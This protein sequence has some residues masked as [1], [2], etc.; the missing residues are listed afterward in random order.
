MA[1][2]VLDSDFGIQIQAL[3]RRVQETLSYERGSVLF[4]SLE[5][6]AQQSDIVT[7][8]A[9][10]IC[11]RAAAGTLLIDA[12]FQSKRITQQME[13]QQGHGLSECLASSSMWY[14]SV[15]ATSCEKLRFL[16]SGELDWEALPELPDAVQSLIKAWKSSFG[17][18]VVDGGPIDQPLTP[19]LAQLA[20][21]TY[22]TVRLGADEREELE[23]ARERLA[24]WGANLQGCIT[25]GPA[26]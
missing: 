16:R 9:M 18:V 3:S 11:G 8:L 6:N 15:V 14:D 4:V 26:L 25:V 22:L 20:D 10:H 7:G 1:A 24:A 21:T 5:D 12:D 2:R 17:L 13:Q 19:Y 23:A